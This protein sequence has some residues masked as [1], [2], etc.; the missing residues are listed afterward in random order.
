[1]EINRSNKTQPSLT[2]RIVLCIVL[3]TI[4]KI[5]NFIPIPGIDRDAFFATTSQNSNSSTDAIVNVLNTFSGGSNKLFG[6]LSLGILPYINASIIIQLLTTS[7]PYLKKLQKDEGEYGRRKIVEFTRYLTVGIAILQSIGVTLSLKSLIFNWNFFTAFNIS[8]VLIAG[9]LI[10]LWF[11]ELITKDGIGNGSSLLICFNIVSNLPDQIK[12]IFLS[13]NSQDTLSNTKALIALPLIFLATTIGCVYLN[14]AT[15]KIPLVS[16][17][18]LSRTDKYERLNQ[19][20]SNL[21][22]KIN[23]AG[24][25]P[26]I[27]TSSI[28]VIGSS[29]VQFLSNKFIGALNF[30]NVILFNVPILIWGGKLLFWLI[31]AG[32]IFFFTYFYSTIIIDAKDVSEQLRKNSVIIKGVTPGLQTEEYLTKLLNKIASLNAIFLFTAILIFQLLGLIFNFNSL[33][34]ND[35][36][37]GFTSQ[38]ILVNVLIDVIQKIRGYLMEE[39][40]EL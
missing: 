34:I 3:L 25:M 24:I 17:R 10:V 2:D 31:Y 16:A 32:L 12:N 14:E 1:M 7:I 20:K 13:L 35:N 28:M 5:G 18:Q 29:V 33:N 37:L 21:P 8:I 9:S 27:F 15:I 39:E 38:I 26:L 23:Q 6:L 22:L 4:V 19:T 30:E 40:Y 36:G 11:S